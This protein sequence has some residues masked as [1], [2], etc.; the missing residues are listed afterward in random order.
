MTLLYLTVGFLAGVATAAV[1]G[2]VAAERR[3]LRPPRIRHEDAALANE[4]AQVVV[5][6]RGWIPLGVRNRAAAAAI[7]QIDLYDLLG[8][9]RCSHGQPLGESCYACDRYPTR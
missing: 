4:L 7:A 1:L 6:H 2:A 5:R 3:L 9:A 8:E